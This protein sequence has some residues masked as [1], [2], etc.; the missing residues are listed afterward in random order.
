MS[1]NLKPSDEMVIT[2]TA[3]ALVY[4]IFNGNTPNLADIRADE[5]SNMNTH[6]AVK[7]AIITS[8][9]AVGSLSLIAKSPTV[10]TVGGAMILFEGWKYHFA[11]HGVDGTQAK[12]V[13]GITS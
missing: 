3:V 10:F 11:N 2:A 5:K 12:P 7:M 9:A 6:A 4:A 13:N 1:I 8:V